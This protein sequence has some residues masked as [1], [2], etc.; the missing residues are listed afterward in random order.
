VHDL[1]VSYGDAD[2]G[3]FITAVGVSGVAS[4]DAT[5]SYAWPGDNTDLTD[6]RTITVASTAYDLCIAVL[7]SSQDVL[8]DVA[9]Q[10]IVSTYRAD[11]TS[12]NHFSQY[13]AAKNSVGATTTFGW[14]GTIGDVDPV[15]AISLSGVGP[16]QST[17]T[18]TG[19]SA[20]GSAGAVTASV[21]GTDETADLIGNTGTGSVGTP[22]TSIGIGITGNQGTGSA[23]D[24]TP[25]VGA[26]LTA[27]AGTGSAG[28][29]VASVTV[30]LTGVSGTGTAGSVTAAAQVGI[31]GATATGAVG[32]VA[33]GKSFNLTGVSATGSVGSIASGGIV[34]A[35][36]GNQ[37]FGIVGRVAPPAHVQVGG[38]QRGSGHRWRSDST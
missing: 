1:A 30:A 16:A 10:D 9:G 31:S 25:G 32:S 26:T 29:V 13:V 17:V 3:I 6:P 11:W 4:V 20:A 36:T 15:V 28:T 35:L 7:T 8:T 18:L 12:G 14:T 5:A 33:F 34:C 19:V 23:G 22:T 38:W 21:E 27:V 24:V 2:W 37:A